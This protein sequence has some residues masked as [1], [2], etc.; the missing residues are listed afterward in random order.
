MAVFL[1]GAAITEPGLR[2]EDIVDNSFL[3]LLNPGY[4]DAPM[5][6]PDGP[7]GKRWQP[8]LDTADDNVSEERSK[9]V[10]AGTKRNV[11]A[12]SVVVLRRV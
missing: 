7:F 9:S 4:E 5:V 1:N 2:G 8:L 12:R 6:L 11:V 3:L 10:S